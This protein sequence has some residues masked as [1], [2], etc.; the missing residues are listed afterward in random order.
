ME[1]R[2]DNYLVNFSL[3]NPQVLRKLLEEQLQLNTSIKHIMIFQ[4]IEGSIVAKAS[5]N[6][7]EEETQKA[8]NS[9]AAVLANMCHEYIEFGLEAFQII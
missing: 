1:G 3:F 5:F 4:N 8:L 9:Y 6:Q 7:E 2:F